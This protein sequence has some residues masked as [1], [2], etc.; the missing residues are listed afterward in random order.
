MTMLLTPRCPTC[1]PVV[2]DMVRF[3]R[4]TG[5]RP[6]EVCQI[7]PCDVD[8]SGE[9]WEYRPESHKTEH[10]GLERIIYIGPK[11]QDV[12]CPICYGTPRPTAFPRPIA[13][14]NDT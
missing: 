3:Q 4:L 5:C 14:R 6:G 1:P 9:V 8:R 7:R 12:L 2:A 13:N 10:H 11:A